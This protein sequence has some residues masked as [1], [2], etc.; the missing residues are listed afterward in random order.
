MEYYIY[1]HSYICMC[2]YVCVCVCVC[3]CMASQGVLAVNNPPAN[4]GG[5]RD[6]GSTPGS[7]SPGEGQGNPLQYSCL[8]N[9]VDRGA[10]WATVCR[11]AK[12]LT[13]L[14]QL[15]TQTHRH[16]HTHAQTHTHIYTPHF[17]YP[18]LHCFHVLAIINK[19][20]IS[21]L[22]LLLSHFS[23]VQLCVTP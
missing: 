2:V 18:F 12:S 3:V 19:A 14:K 15:S 20:T 6:A 9:S 5:I 8:K 4:A 11:V 21:M 7:R 16:T 17:L 22:L 13:Q 1:K 10:R 23:R